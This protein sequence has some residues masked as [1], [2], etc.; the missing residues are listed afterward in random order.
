MNWHFYGTSLS[1]RPKDFDE[2][3]KVLHRLPNESSK[4]PFRVKNQDRLEGGR[5]QSAPGP[6]ALKGLITPN[7]SG[8]GGPHKVK[9]QLFSK[10]N[11]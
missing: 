5:G 7:T 6:Q 4:L 2:D 3:S 10:V 11:F 8:S 9:Q 1:D